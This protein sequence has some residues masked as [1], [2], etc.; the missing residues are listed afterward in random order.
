MIW[1]TVSSRSFF[2]PWLY[3]VSPSLVAKNI[4]SLILVLTVWWCPS[5]LS[6]WKRVFALTS[7]FSW[8]NSVNLYTAS[9]CTPRPNLPV[10]PGISWLPTFAFQSPMMK[11]TFFFGVSSMRSCRSSQNHSTSASS[12]LEFGTQPWITVMLM[13]CLRNEP[14]SFCHFWDC[15]QVLHFRLFVFCESYS[16]PSKGFLPTVV[17]I[18]VNWI[19]FAHPHSFWFTDL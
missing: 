4:I 18:M 13:V 19:K 5:L 2:F 9:F 7:V 12:A 1:V 8:Q 14:R 16:I 15:I 11:W 17:D 6:C 3:R 10:I